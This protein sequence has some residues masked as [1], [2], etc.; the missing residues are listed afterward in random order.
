VS[1]VPSTDPQKNPFPSWIAAVAGDEIVVRPDEPE[2]EAR[3][4]QWGFGL[5]ADQRAVVT[6]QEIE[7][8]VRAVVRAR[9]RWLAERGLAPM[10]FYCWPD[11]QAGQLRF[12]LVSSGVRGSFKCSVDVGPLLGAVVAEFLSGHSAESLPVWV[13]TVP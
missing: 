11:A 5:D 1:A 2:T 7:E 10:H 3:C 6:V 8:F 12:S 4:N 13:T 9:G